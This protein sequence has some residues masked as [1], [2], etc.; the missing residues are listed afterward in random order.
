MA[1]SVIR[2]TAVR[3]EKPV[4]K[5]TGPEK[6]VSKPPG[7]ASR[8]REESSRPKL[9]AVQDV[10]KDVEVLKKTSKELKQSNEELKLQMV[11]QEERFSNQL[12]QQG[13]K[14]DKRF[15]QIM[16]LL[17]KAKE[18]SPQ[19]TLSQAQPSFSGFKSSRKRKVDLVEE[20]DKKFW[21]DD[22]RDDLLDLA[23]ENYEESEKECKPI[24]FDAKDTQS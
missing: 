5:V 1:D 8:T 10:S 13:D 11:Q 4:S 15:G 3:S 7:L 18:K 17:T 24:E 12:V 6:P 23:E 2:V 9:S 20:E 19:D 16:E 22:S 14:V 21:D